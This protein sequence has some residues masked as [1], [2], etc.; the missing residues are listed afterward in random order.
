MQIIK[1]EQQQQ[2]LLDKPSLNSIIDFMQKDAPDYFNQIKGKENEW[3]ARIVL[4][5]G[6]M[7]DGSKI[8]FGYLLRYQFRKISIG[9]DM[10]IREIKVPGDMDE[11]LDLMNEINS[12]ADVFNKEIRR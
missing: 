9:Y 12:S 11:F 1:T 10:G 2:E 7:H 6:S 3:I 8:P 5:K 4:M